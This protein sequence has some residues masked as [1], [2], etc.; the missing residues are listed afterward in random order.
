MLLTFEKCPHKGVSAIKCHLE[1]LLT[2]LIY[3]GYF[4]I[5]LLFL[6]I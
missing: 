4:T 6:P 2:I 5:L 1:R 3:F